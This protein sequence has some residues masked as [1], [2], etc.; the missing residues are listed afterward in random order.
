MR[1]ALF[2]M[3]FPCVNCVVSSGDKGMIRDPIPKIV[4]LFSPSCMTLQPMLP[5]PKS[6][7][8]MFFMVRY[9]MVFFSN[10]SKMNQKTNFFVNLLVYINNMCKFENNFEAIH[11]KDYSVVKTF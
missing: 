6:K 11:N 8:N 10:I 3:L 5:E 1:S 9:R 7:P 2:V 4:R